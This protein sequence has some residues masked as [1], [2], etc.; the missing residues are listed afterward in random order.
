MLDT[1]EVSF[2][3]ADIDHTTKV[4]LY[5][6]IYDLLLAQILNGTIA[7]NDRLPSEQYLTQALSVSRITVKRAMNELALARFVRRQRG[8]GT[9]V[10]HD[11]AVSKVG[12]NFQTTIDEPMLV[13]E[14]TKI[15][16]IDNIVE[17]ASPT[18]SKTFV[19]KGDKCVRRITRLHL[20][21][22]EPFCF[23]ITYT[24]R[25]IFYRHTEAELASESI[26]KLLERTG[27]VPVQLTQTITATVAKSNIAQSLRVAPGSPLLRIHRIMLDTT[28]RPIQDITAYYRPDK[29][30]YR[31][32][33]HR[34]S[35]TEKHW[36]TVQ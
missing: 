9:I 6:Q 35:A 15:Q 13:G 14:Q 32:L 4:P 27:H 36:S 26:L 17:T 8:I 28:G 19:L 7:L 18:I 12:G 22:G 21:N 11:V 5:R 2:T 29:F 31:T 16:L 23:D 24:P 30:E 3:P 10:I 33:M 1:G 34:N 25:D 20:L